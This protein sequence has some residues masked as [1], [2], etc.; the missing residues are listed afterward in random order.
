MKICKKMRFDNIT[1]LFSSPHFR[2][3]FENYVQLL[4][5][6]CVTIDPV[7]MRNSLYMKTLSLFLVDDILR[8]GEDDIWIGE[9]GGG[10]GRRPVVRQSGRAQRHKL[11]KK[12]RSKDRYNQRGLRTGR[13]RTFYINPNPCG[14]VANM[15]SKTQNCYDKFIIHKKIVKNL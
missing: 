11:K 15:T 3:F 13:F 12:Q 8:R 1:T 9:G 4:Q 5:R 6:P 7:W 14:L 2:T 10:L